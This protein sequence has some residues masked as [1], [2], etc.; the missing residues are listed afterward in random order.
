[1]KWRRVKAI[2]VKES[3]QI[4]RDPRSLMIALL[5]PLLQMFLL[6]YGISLDIKQIPLCAY[7]NE[8]SQTSQDLLRRF[9]ASPYF[10]LQGQATSYAEVGRSL[11]DGRC[12]IAIVI[13]SGFSK[14]LNDTGQGLV[15]ALLD[16]T[17]TNNA[18]LAAGYASA[19]IASYSAAAQLQTI[20]QRGASVQ[21]LTPVEVRARVWFNEDMVSRN[22]IIPGVVALVMAIIG[23]QLSSLTIAREWE[24][25]TMELLVS[26]P[27]QPL[28]LM[29]GKL[30]PYFVVGMVDACICLAL[31]VFWFEV[32][33]RG[34]L[35]ALFFTTGLFLTVVLCIGYYV[36]VSI[37]SQV[38]ASQ[39]ALLLTMLPT[40]LLSGFSFPIDQMPTAVQA[41][42]YI[43]SGR[44]YVTILKALFLKGAPWGELAPPIFCLAL[45]AAA[46]VLLA[47][48]AF[49][50]TLD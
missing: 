7:D 44:Y 49:R 19:V 31:A 33:F 6:G 24:R 2:V 41:V 1:M 35:S 30:L 46:M 4:V 37:R 29:L 18:S 8:G 27:I 12:S 5:I 26:T 16:A 21:T 17:D 28:E 47:A 22:F 40:T 38:G 45:Y 50:K 10:S 32:P 43:V 48:R 23:S 14:R 39:V 13:P 36:S 15:Q 34:T 25:G 20:E 11:D 3:L 9:S 42:T